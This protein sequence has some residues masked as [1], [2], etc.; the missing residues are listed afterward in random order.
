MTSFDGRFTITDVEELYV[1][2]MK[3]NCSLLKKDNDLQCY[4]VLILAII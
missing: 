4:R 3:I 2:K 1:S